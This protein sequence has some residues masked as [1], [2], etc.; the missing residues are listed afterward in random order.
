ML[1]DDPSV[2]G[3]RGTLV[4]AVD[5]R[6]G[7][8]CW[9][10]RLDVGEIQATPAVDGGQAYYTVWTRDRGDEESTGAL[11]ALDVETGEVTWQTGLPRG[12]DGPPVLGTDLA[13]VSAFNGPLVAVSLDSG[14]EVW[15][16]E[17]TALF[18]TGK[19][20]REY[21]QP[22]Y[23]LGALTPDALVARLEANTEAS[24]RLRAFDPAT[25]ETLWTRVAE[26]P[27]TWVTTPTGA[28]DDVFVAESRDDSAPNRLLRLDART[29]DVREG[30]AYE[31]WAHH[32]PTLADGTALFAAGGS[33][34]AFGT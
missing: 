8:Q 3:E 11:V 5:A 6:S 4:S 26:G 9:Q 22:S 20:G 21:A 28:G 15:R 25:G 2:G 18:G 1:V 29:G 14:D 19:A 16:H 33:L 13:Y 17:Q 34:R 24:D 7:E 23:E 32:S 30:V 31:T 10:T 12:V 27:D